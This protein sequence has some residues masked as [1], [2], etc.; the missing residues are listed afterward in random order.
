MWTTAKWI[1]VAVV[2]TVFGGL[3]F[4]RTIGRR[5][6]DNIKFSY[7]DLL[8]YSFLGLEMGFLIT[9]HWQVFH[10]PLVFLVVFAFVGLVV[11]GGRPLKSSQRS[12]R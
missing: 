2:V 9:F 3:R 12:A 11:T 7:A 4:M 6:A 5:K 10:I 1:E 8:F